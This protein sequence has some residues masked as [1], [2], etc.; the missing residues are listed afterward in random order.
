MTNSTTQKCSR[1]LFAHRIRVGVRGH[2]APEE[3]PS[4]SHPGG[5]QRGSELRLRQ[6][7][8]QQETEASEQLHKGYEQR[9][10]RCA[11]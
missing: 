8:P 9:G 3:H 6:H 5:P 2:S 10:P 11:A 4:A 1:H 7:V